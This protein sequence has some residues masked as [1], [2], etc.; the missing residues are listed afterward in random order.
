M[1]VSIKDKRKGWADKDAALIILE[2]YYSKQ[3]IFSGN[4]GLLILDADL[5][6]DT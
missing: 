6:R 5:I 2:L 4:L 3:P 1:Y